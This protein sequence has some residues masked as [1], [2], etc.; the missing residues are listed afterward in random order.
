MAD[1]C[2]LYY[3]SDRRQFPG[4]ESSRRS[5]L[6]AKIAE[7]AHAGVD[8]V[9]LR[10]KDLSARELELL[11]GEAVRVI[12]EEQRPANSEPRTATRLLINSRV[13][14]AL[15]SGADGVH[16]RSDDI[17]P[18]DVREIWRMCGA[19]SHAREKL[20]IVAMSCHCLSDVVRAQSLS[21][22]FAVFGPV[23]E[24]RDAP[25]TEPKGCAELR[26]ACAVEIPV[27]ALGG[28]TLANAASCRA[29]GAAGLAGIRLFQE[30][31]IEE[32][33]RA[34]RGI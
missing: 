10:E 20:P 18:A 31:K 34:L 2:L 25:G 19:A 4:D 26:A 28:V 7:A 5:A 16:L 24:K 13:D 15:A 32:V 17:A 3:I 6:L 27:L 8:Y 21:A 22:D 33:V 9:Q 29:A 23:F 11:A 1:H 14:I 30:N 12:R